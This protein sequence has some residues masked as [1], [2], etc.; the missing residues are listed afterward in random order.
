MVLSALRKLKLGRPT[1][2]ALT[3]QL[4]VIFATWNSSR[5][6]LKTIKSIFCSAD[7]TQKYSITFLIIKMRKR[8]F[9][10]IP[11]GRDPI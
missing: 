9:C 8:S 10:D 6:V 7:P 1:K 11:E 4:I 2:L 3:M 5:H